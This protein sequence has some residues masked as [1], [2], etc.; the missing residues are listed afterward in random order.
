M[1]SQLFNNAAHKHSDRTV[2][3]DG[4]RHMTYFELQVYVEWS[5]RYFQSLGIQTGHRVAI[6]IPNRHEFVISLLG[7]LPL[8]GVAVPLPV[9]E[10][11]EEIRAALLAGKVHAAITIPRYRESLSSILSQ[12]SKT[13]WPLHKIPLAVFEEDNIATASGTL[14]PPEAQSTAPLNV[15][16]KND[17]V[18]IG[19]LSSLM[20]RFE[21]YPAASIV[22]R[23]TA[24]GVIAKPVTHRALVEAA[25]NFV[26]ASQ[27]TA[28]DCILSVLPLSQSYGLVSGLLA[29]FVCGARLILHERFEAAAVLRALEQERV[30]IYPG[31]ASMFGKLLDASSSA[32]RHAHSLRMCFCDGNN[33]APEV[34]ETFQREFGVAVQSL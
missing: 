2:L 28:G 11:P 22:H 16:G 33:L 29:A 12:T 10:D 3:V 17:H 21:D 23:E 18:G 1:I 27:M 31:A 6:Y 5:A 30:T 14:F 32:S 25:E 20:G 24:G 13:E 15:N 8:G 34:K 9:S 4:E 19:L 26:H 7:M